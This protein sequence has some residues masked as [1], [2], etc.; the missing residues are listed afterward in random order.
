MQTSRKS[1]LG[2][3]AVVAII[4]IGLLGN[5]AA[6]VRDVLVGTPLPQGLAKFVSQEELDGEFAILLSSCRNDECN[7]RQHEMKHAVS[8][9]MDSGQRIRFVH[10]CS[11]L[12]PDKEY[13]PKTASYHH[14]IVADPDVVYQDSI[15]KR[16][17]LPSLILLKDGVIQRILIDHEFD[18]WVQS[19]RANREK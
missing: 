9:S 10:V 13:D 18:Q 2:V 19:T 1:K 4:G 7:D 5:R 12:A 6:D 16:I 15:T 3:A 17:P 8:D 11:G 14:S